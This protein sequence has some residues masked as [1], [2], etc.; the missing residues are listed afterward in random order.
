MLPAKPAHS[1]LERSRRKL[2][3]EVS[4]EENEGQAKFFK[5]DNKKRPESRSQRQEILPHPI[6][7]AM[8]A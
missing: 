5:E 1:E 8:E 7:T 6:P 3:K 4:N 2:K